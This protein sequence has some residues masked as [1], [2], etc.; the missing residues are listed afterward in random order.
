M[1]YFPPPPPPPGVHWEDGSKGLQIFAIFWKYQ[2]QS[3][4]HRLDFCRSLGVLQNG[5]V[6]IMETKKSLEC[7]PSGIYLKFILFNSS[8]TEQLT[9]VNQFIT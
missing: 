2:K 3:N 8:P 5:N 9:Q 4:L 7:P 6:N 1:F